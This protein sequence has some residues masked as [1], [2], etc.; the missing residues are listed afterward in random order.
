MS[1]LRSVLCVFSTYQEDASKAASLALLASS[2]PLDSDPSYPTSTPNDKEPRTSGW[3][4]ASPEA[5]VESNNVF[6]SGNL[7][8]HGT[9]MGH[10]DSHP[11]TW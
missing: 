7:T 3:E 11:S 4:P 9:S 2:I 5:L 8:K 6:Y 1:V 10:L